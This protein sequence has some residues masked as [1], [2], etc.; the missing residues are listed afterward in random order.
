MFSLSDGRK[1][2]WEE[3]GDE[4]GKPVFYL[5]GW[6]GSR[7]RS[8]FYD[9]LGKK[10]K[11]RIISPDRPGYGKSDYKEGRTLLDYPDDIAELADHL[12]IKKFAVVGVSGGGPYAATL[13]YKIPKRLTKVGIVVGLA[14]PYAPGIMRDMPLVYRFGWENYQRFPIFAYLGALYR[15]V[16]SRY[17]PTL[18][19]K[20]AF[21]SHA[22]QKMIGSVEKDMAKVSRE[23]FVQGPRGPALDLMLYTG[24]WGF[25]LRK[26]KTK[27][28]LWYGEDDKNVPL[29]MGKYYQKNIPG[30]KLKTYPGEGHLISI[31]H[32]EEIFKTLVVGG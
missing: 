6:P 32:A 17:F 30:S 28:F 20:I 7:Y 14:P 10:L 3:Y 16:E 12:H 21:L 19:S 15:S 26:I 22:D 29:A 27:V 24:R 5:H 13:A 9:K 23:A 2:C 11:I 1:V 18:F 4:R 8:S 25:D 31:S